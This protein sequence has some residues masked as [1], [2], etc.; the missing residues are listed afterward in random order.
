ME[1]TYFIRINGNINSEGLYD[2][3]RHFG[4][5]VTDAGEYTAVYGEADL[6]TASRVIYHAS[7]FGDTSVQ[8]IHKR[9]EP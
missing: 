4:A 6:M 1:V 3:I 9:S 2:L 7:L 8:V 5:N